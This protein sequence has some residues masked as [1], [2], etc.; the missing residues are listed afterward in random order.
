MRGVLLAA[1]LLPLAGIAVAQTALRPYAVVGD[2]IP[3]SLTGRPGDPARGMALIGDRTKSLCILCHAGP[4]PNPHLHG[5]LAPDLKGVGGRFSVAQLRL[6]VVDMK[7][8]VPATIMPSYHRIDD[9]DRRVAAAWRGRP[10]LA[11]EE[12]EDI[13]AYLATLKD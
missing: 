2:A 13:V 12:I 4:M 8:L 7:R 9:A 5:N 1:A 3:A 10:I 6:R 11:A